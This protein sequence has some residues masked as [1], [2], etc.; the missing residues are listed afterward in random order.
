MCPRIIN[1]RY[2]LSLSHV[3]SL[4]KRLLSLLS[5]IFIRLIFYSLVSETFWKLSWAI[6]TN[7][8]TPTNVF[9]IRDEMQATTCETLQLNSPGNVG[10]SLIQT[11]Q[12][13]DR[14][15]SANHGRL[16][17]ARYQSELR[18]MCAVRGLFSRPC[19]VRQRLA[20]LQNFPRLG[21]R[22]SGRCFDSEGKLLKINRILKTINRG[23]TF[24]DYCGPKDGESEHT[25]S[26]SLGYSNAQWRWTE[27]Q[28]RL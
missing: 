5:E 6:I 10:Y 27:G 19:H 22:G 28:I 8:T 26:Y 1:K 25:F 2:D 14:N 3:F 24:G 11:S 7:L 13:A 17:N 23:Q 20:G 21:F 16:Y 12:W 9:A 18:T 15:R 4:Q